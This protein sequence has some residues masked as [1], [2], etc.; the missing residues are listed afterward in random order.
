MERS[1]IKIDNL[2]SIATFKRYMEIHVIPMLQRIK[3][4]NGQE[5]KPANSFIMAL[6]YSKR[7]DKRT[8]K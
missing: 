7:F 2:Y 1:T 8:K 5:G 6:E 4:Y 3:K